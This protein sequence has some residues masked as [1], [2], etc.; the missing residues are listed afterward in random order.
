M[1]ESFLEDPNNVFTVTDCPQLW[2]RSTETQLC[3]SFCPT[4]NVLYVFFST[5]RNVFCVFED[6]TEDWVVQ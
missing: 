1:T 4:R 2:T 5:T 6:D 3:P